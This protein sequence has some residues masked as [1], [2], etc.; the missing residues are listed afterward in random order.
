MMIRWQVGE[1]V[2]SSILLTIYRSAA[3][4]SRRSST[5]EPMARH[6]TDLLQGRLE[7]LVVAALSLEP[8]RDWGIGQRLQQLSRDVFQVS[9]GSRYPALQRMRN[10]GWITS[11][12]R[13]KENYPRG[14]CT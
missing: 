1:K 8:R 13:T 7:P 14:R 5:G 2:I 3:R 6:R 9:Q 12:S 4:L 11:E 10:K